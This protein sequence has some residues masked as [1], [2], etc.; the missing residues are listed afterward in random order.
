MTSIAVT[1][2]KNGQLVNGLT[3]DPVI[4]IRRQDTGAAVVTNDP[5]TD[6]GADG[7]YR[8]T[9]V[10]AAGLDYH[11]IV[12]ADPNQTN[13][14]DAR[15]FDGSFNNELNDI[16]NDRGLNPTTPKTITENLIGEDYDS[17]VA[18]PTPVNKDITKVNNVTTIDRT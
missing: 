9:F 7:E 18:S 3:D 8:Y 1:L 6:S 4:T 5:M 14:V 13:Q 10:P 11:F 17:A 2:T 16:W 15:Y 12:D